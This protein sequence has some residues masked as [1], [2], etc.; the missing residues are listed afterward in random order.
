MKLKAYIV[1]W[2]DLQEWLDKYEEKIKF[3]LPHINPGMNPNLYCII[4][5]EG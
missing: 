1:D 4:I 2:P 5:D 3:I